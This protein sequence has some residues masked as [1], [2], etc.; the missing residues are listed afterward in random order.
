MLLLLHNNLDWEPTS[1]AVEQ[2]LT[3]HLVQLILGA[4]LMQTGQWCTVHILCDFQHGVSDC[5]QLVS[6]LGRPA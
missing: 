6:H 1:Q 2:R 5:S 3:L 4:G